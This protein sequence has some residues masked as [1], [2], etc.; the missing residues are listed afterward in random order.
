MAVDTACNVR[1]GQTDGGKSA[2]AAVLK[3]AAIAAA[4]YNAYKAYD[5]AYAEYKLAK[6][7]YQLSKNWLDYYR[8]YYAPVE[9]QELRE[10][11]N[12]PETTP[13]YETARGRARVTA[14][15]QFKGRLDKA[16][17]CT[18]RYCTGLRQDMILEA[19]TAQADAL[20][21]ADGIGYR[22]E[23][24]Y[25]EARNDVRFEKMLNTAKRG[26]DMVADNVSLA[27]ATSG[28]YGDFAE[29]AWKGL[30]SAGMYIGYTSARHAP[31]YP[32]TYASQSRAPVDAVAD[33]LAE[34]RG[35]VAVRNAL[36]DI[37][38]MVTN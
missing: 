18:S 33:A 31:N 26:R 28:I 21:L 27:R 1:R 25:V 5:I 34:A 22:S 24:A 2:V 30:Q 29:Q 17:K 20:A 36:S 9:D 6:K 23:R 7:Y 8:D 11:M 38:G 19:T 13:D 32:T 16:F 37:S 15:M 14:I 4:G 3:A 10:A 12:I 35:Q